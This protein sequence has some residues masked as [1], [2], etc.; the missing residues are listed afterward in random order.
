MSDRPSSRT[1]GPIGGT[2]LY[3]GVLMTLTTLISLPG[4]GRLI[5]EV[6]TPVTCPHEVRAGRN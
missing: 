6:I 5:G 3:G 1:K 4:W 2:N